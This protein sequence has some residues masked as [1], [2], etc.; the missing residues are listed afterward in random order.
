MGPGEKPTE[1]DLKNAQELGKR[2]AQEDWALLTGGRCVGVMDAASKGAKEA[3][4]V[5]LGIIPNQDPE[6]ISEHV[7]YPIITDMGAARNNINVLTSD[8]VIAC[9]IGSG[10]ASEIALALK[11]KK[12]VVLLNDS[13]K[14]H[15]FFKELGGELVFIAKT[16]K[17]AIET[18]RG[19]VADL[20][21]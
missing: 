1:N 16:P 18:V 15:E 12:N 7:D 5:T 14:S 17:E 11:A 21:K 9:G 8:V 2:I 13:Q 3:G 4:G 20:V 19:I 10:T 6:F